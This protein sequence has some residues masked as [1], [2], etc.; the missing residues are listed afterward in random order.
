MMYAFLTVGDA[1]PEKLP[2]V[3]AEAFDVQIGDIDVSD[4]SELEDRNWDASVSCE[5]EVLEGDLQWSLTV[6]AS[7]TVQHRP[8]EDQLSLALARR[9]GSPVFSD[10]GGGV[11]W[12][13]KVALP[14]G[15]FTLARVVESDQGEAG[16]SVEAAEAPIV[17]LPNVQVTRF[18]EVV[19]A[20]E[21]ATPVT[22]EVLPPGLTG[23]ERKL[24]GLLVNWERLCVR[25]GSDWPPSGWYSAAMYKEDLEYRDTLGAS[26]GDLSDGGAEIKAAVERIDSVF[27]ALTIDDDG[28]SISAPGGTGSSSESARPWYWRRRPKTAPWV[29]D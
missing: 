28:R 2:K 25:M 14:D 8:P 26:L 22:D 9:L 6:Y 12:I 20:F 19:R 27:R 18:P 3:L 23:A 16:V 17:E 7:E 10:W 15:G 21:I 5:Y 24:R 11:P 1:V 29:A 4:I 13:R